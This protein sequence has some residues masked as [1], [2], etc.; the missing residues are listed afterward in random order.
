MK[1][2]FASPTKKAVRKSPKSG[3]LTLP[4]QVKSAA[5]TVSA[6]GS[7]FTLPQ[8]LEMRQR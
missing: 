1:S 7:L 4:S 2:A 5:H 3:G 8:G 6:A